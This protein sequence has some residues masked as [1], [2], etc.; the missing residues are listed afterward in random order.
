MSRHENICLHYCKQ[1]IS[2]LKNSMM[3]STGFRKSSKSL[4]CNQVTKVV[5]PLPVS[6]GAPH[7]PATGGASHTELLNFRNTQAADL[8]KWHALPLQNSFSTGSTCKTLTSP[9]RLNWGILSTYKIFSN[10]SFWW[11]CLHPLYLQKT[12]F[13]SLLW[14]FCCSSWSYT[15]LVCPVIRL[16]NL[17][18]SIVYCRSAWGGLSCLSSSVFSKV[19][20]IHSARSVTTAWVICWWTTCYMR[21][22]TVPYS[23]ILLMLTGRNEQKL[24]QV[25]KNTKLRLAFWPSRLAL[26]KYLAKPRAVCHFFIP[27]DLFGV[28]N[29][30][31]GAADRTINKVNHSCAEMKEM[32]LELIN[33]SLWPIPPKKKFFLTSKLSSLLHKCKTWEMSGFSLH[34]VQVLFDKM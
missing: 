2:H 18:M 32:V 25:E 15:N 29:L 20:R 10:T 1:V 6:R 26:P 14:H 13:K 4:T 34:L 27:K 9:S 12:F 21:T 17:V 24:L 33:Q 5:N 22:A 16:L 11:K 19:C 7:F 23:F 28:P 3:A 31:P 30:I 8:Y